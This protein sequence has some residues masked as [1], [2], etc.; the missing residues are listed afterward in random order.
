M[1]EDKIVEL[2][3]EEIEA[4]NRLVAEDLAKRAAP[5]DRKSETLEEAEPAILEPAIPEPEFT[6]YKST[7]Q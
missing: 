7:D 2:T 4:R 1:A 5:A 6:P 3:R